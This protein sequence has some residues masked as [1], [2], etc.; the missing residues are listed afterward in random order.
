MQAA[1]NSVETINV[2][3]SGSQAIFGGNIVFRAAAQPSVGVSEVL[4]SFT[5]Q[6]QVTRLEK[7]ILGTGGE[8]VYEIAAGEIA[9]I[10]FTRIDY[11]FEA[12]LENGTK[13][14][15]QEY[16]L[17]YDDTRF[18][19]QDQESGIFQV[20][21][22]DED[23]TLGQ[24]IINV[25]QA[26]LEQAQSILEIDPPEPVQIY[27]YSS[28]RDLQ[29]AL[30]MTGGSWVAGHAS[31]DLGMIMISVPSGPERKLELQRQIPHEI[32]HLLQYQVTGKYFAR[33]PIW[34]MEGMASLTE[35][36][37][38]P[39]Y[40]RVLKDT[41]RA[42]GLIPMETLCSSFPNEA[43]PVFRAYAQS[44][45]FVRYLNSTYG[46]SGLL[47]LINEYKNGM[48]CTE[49]VEAAFSTSLGQL[50]YRWKQEVLGLNAGGLAV[51]RLSPYLLLGLLLLIPVMFSFWP[52]RASKGKL[53]TNS[54]GEKP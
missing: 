24:Q 6:S 44:E 39:E 14:S 13:V 52:F 25:A 50:E 16:H 11:S 40:S 23:P 38:N 10:P 12:R 37:P 49:G 5:P 2:L 36:Y 54:A 20:H 19:W 51:R 45:S 42:D 32:M 46:N 15:S 7:M 30:M 48:G 35:L 53:S 43:G 22:N 9:L 18:T 27:A 3:D 41:A 26:G 28:S 31:P 8:A 47:S 34:L 33:Q 29:D 1:S 17:Q 4:V 21:W